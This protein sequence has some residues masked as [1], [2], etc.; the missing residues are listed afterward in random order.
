MSAKFGV[1]YRVLLF[2][3]RIILS[4]ASIYL[5]ADCSCQANEINFLLKV[6]LVDLCFIYPRYV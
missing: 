5:K 1:I 4:L 6:H 3:L 2:T